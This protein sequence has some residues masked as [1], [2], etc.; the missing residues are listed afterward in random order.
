MGRDDKTNEK[1]LNFKFL[2]LLF[3]IKNLVENES[4]CNNKEEHEMF[5]SLL[6]ECKDTYPEYIFKDLKSSYNVY[7]G[8]SKYEEINFWSYD[9]LLDPIYKH[10]EWYNEVVDLTNKY[11]YIIVK[12]NLKKEIEKE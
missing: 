7:I 12:I 8:S 10:L 2:S 3:F 6:K 1:I 4:F 5:T 11:L 9:S